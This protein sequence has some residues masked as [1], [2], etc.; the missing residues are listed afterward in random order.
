MHPLPEQTE[1]TPNHSSAETGADSVISRSDILSCAALA[2][3]EVIVPL[4]VGQQEGED[5]M[6]R[7]FRSALI[8][9]LAVCCARRS[10]GSV[11]VSGAISLG[12]LVDMLT[13]DLFSLRI[14][15]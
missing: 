4:I 5:E 14:V 9:H 8:R 13:R 10:V 6:C 3:E 1:K 15:A 12:A 2:A 11:G 7:L